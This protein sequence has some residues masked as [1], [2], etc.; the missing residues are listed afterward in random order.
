MRNRVSTGLNSSRRRLGLSLIEVV[1]STLLMGLILV[2]ALRTVGASIQTGVD[3][4]DRGKAVMLAEHLLSEILQSDYIEPVETPLFGVETSEGGGTRELYDD[5]D[6]YD[7]WRASPPQFKDG[8]LLPDL[9]GW[10]RKVLV[11]HL[12]PDSLQTSLADDD[13]QGIK[14]IEVIIEYNGQ[15]LARLGTIQTTAWI[16]MIPEPGNDQTTGSLPSGT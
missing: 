16:D 15:E 5:V 13:D 4:A 11:Y 7:D 6:D 14:W 3:T 9:N 12:D 1:V 10:E 8:T 2:A